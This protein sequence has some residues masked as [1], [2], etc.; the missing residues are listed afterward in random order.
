MFLRGLWDVSL[1][2]YLTDISERDLMPAGQFN[3]YEVL[4]QGNGRHA[5]GSNYLL[6]CSTIWVNDILLNIISVSSK[7]FPNSVI[8]KPASS[9]TLYEL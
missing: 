8:I 6:V 5:Q 7:I 3:F 9:V 4:N 2:G 1:I